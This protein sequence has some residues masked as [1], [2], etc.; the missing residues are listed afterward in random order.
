MPREGDVTMCLNCGG[1]FYFTKD[2]QLRLP[3]EMEKVWIQEQYGITLM[4]MARANIVGSRD[5]RKKNESESET[6]Q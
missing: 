4:Q 2:L 5:L 1:M 6:P 3:T